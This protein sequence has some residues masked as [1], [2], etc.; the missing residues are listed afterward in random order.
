[1]HL[2]SLSVA[3]I[4]V[5]TLYAKAR[6]TG[7]VN[8]LRRGGSQNSETPILRDS[9]RTPVQSSSGMENLTYGSLERRDNEYNEET[10]MFALSP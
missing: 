10:E 9:S 7:P 3:L 2:F 5:C 6:A 4:V 8:T 1:M